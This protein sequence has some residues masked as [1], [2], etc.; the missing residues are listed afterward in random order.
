MDHLTP[1]PPYNATA[2][3]IMSIA[4]QLFM[5]RGYRA[6]SINDIVRAAE[7]TKPTL[8]YYFPD[9]EELFVQMGLHLLAS[10]HGAMQTA[11]A[12]QATLAGRLVA[13]AEIL[14]NDRDGDMRMMRHEMYQHLGPPHQERLAQAFHVHL[15]MPIFDV[16][17][18]GIAAGELE[19][20]A[21]GELTMIFLGL[22]EAF[23]GAP[24]RNDQ[25][26]LAPAASISFNN[27]LISPLR[28]VNLFLHGVAP[29]SLV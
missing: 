17:Q 22:M 14:L 16:M 2:I 23:H 15:F 21:P 10:M 8:Y 12:A 28:V 26:S 24:T 7:I 3:K 13:L 1:E 18:E 25:G 9:K 4:A 6:V 29:R 20:A 19:N 27:M 11:I 5:Q